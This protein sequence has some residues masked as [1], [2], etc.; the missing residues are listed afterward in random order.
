VLF[1]VEPWMLKDPWNVREAPGLVLWQ[2]IRPEVNDG[3]RRLRRKPLGPPTGEMSKFDLGLVRR[4]IDTL[5]SRPAA[6][7]AAAG[8]SNTQE[9]DGSL[10]GSGPR[11]DIAEIRAIAADIKLI[12]PNGFVSSMPRINAERLAL[13]EDV[14]RLM[15]SDG[16]AVHM[17]LAPF[18]PL[19]WDFFQRQE[20]FRAIAVV[21]QTVLEL[22]EH[23]GMPVYGSYDPAVCGLE[24]HDFVDPI[25]PSESGINRVLRQC[26]R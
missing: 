12:A 17:F 13:F 14:L 26:L 21:E 10:K 19:T 11:R 22:G 24:E 9:A 18:H 20:Q 1:G 4:A 16:V 8:V 3:L 23:L 6:P 7:L 25:H 5:A 2:S 15:K